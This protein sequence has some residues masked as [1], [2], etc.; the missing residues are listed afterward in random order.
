MLTENQYQFITNCVV[1]DLVAI[2]HQEYGFPLI[3]SFGMVYN[4]EIYQKL[5]NRATGLYLYSP[6]YTFEYLRKE[7]GLP[8][9]TSV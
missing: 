1:E 2:L 9:S 6:Y 7:L 4:S 8:E 3:D 5:I